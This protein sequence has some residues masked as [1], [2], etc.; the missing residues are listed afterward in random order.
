MFDLILA[1]LRAQ[2]GPKVLLD[3]AD[4]VEV[5]GISVGQQANLRSEGKFPI[6]VQKIGNRVKVSIYELAKYLAG[7]AT[8]HAKQEI[9]SFP[10]KI[11]RTEKKSK[12]GLLEKNWW[13][14]HHDQ[15]VSIIRKSILFD[16]LK[17]SSEEST[18]TKL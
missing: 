13:A 2:F 16:E 4:L 11:S 15:V 18:F 17:H 6:A 10:V 8:Q 14:F 9:A 1:D 12:K 5:I 7:L 3:P